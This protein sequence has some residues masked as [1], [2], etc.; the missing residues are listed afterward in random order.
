[1]RRRIR[2]GVVALEIVLGRERGAVPDDW[3][4]QRIEGAL[5][6]VYIVD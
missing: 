1:M 2:G 6:L 3:L 4:G 5:D